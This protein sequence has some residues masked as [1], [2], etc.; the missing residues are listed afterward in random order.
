MF[1]I[2]EC[3]AGGRRTVPAGS[4]VAHLSVADV[5]HRGRGAGRC[6]AVRLGSVGGGLVVTPGG[7]WRPLPTEARPWAS[8]PGGRGR[9]RRNTTERERLLRR[10][11]RMA[12]VRLP[13]H[14]GVERR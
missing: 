14:H 7:A 9:R 10:E 11:P 3:T 13:P 5:R 8:A 1:A 12:A 2:A 6:E 4:A